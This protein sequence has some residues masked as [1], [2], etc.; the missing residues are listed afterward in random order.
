MG[1]KKHRPTTRSRNLQNNSGGMKSLHADPLNVLA[2]VGSL[3][4]Y[5]AY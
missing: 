2:Y 1:K 4:D 5:Y 3:I